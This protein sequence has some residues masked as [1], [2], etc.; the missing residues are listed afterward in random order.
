MSSCFF[1]TP[2]P[3]TG[4]SRPD[5][6]WLHPSARICLGFT[7]HKTRTKE[8]HEEGFLQVIQIQLTLCCTTEFLAFVKTVSSL[9]PL[10][11]QTQGWQHPDR[12]GSEVRAEERFPR[13]PQRDSRGPDRHR[14]IRRKVSR[15]RGAGGCRTEGDGCGP[16][17]SGPSLPDVRLS[18]SFE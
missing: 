16:V 1:V 13:W 14:P 9:L 4:A 10:I 18:S 2:L 11:S 5:P 12:P 7:H 8:E 17:C 3:L 6:V 15:Q